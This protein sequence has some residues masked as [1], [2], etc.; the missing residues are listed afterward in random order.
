MADG[1]VTANA[2]NNLG[3]NF[4]ADLAGNVV[5]PYA[6]LAFG[7]SGTQTEASTSNP[8]PVVANANATV[9]IAAGTAV[10]G[11][12]LTDAGSLTLAT[13]NANANVAINSPVT[14]TGS[15]AVAGTV[16]VS[17]GNVNSNVNGNVVVSGAVT[18][19]APVTL[20]AN[21]NVALN[22]PVTLQTNAN[23]SINSPITLQAN[24]NVVVSALTG[25]NVN[26]NV[27]G[28]V[29]VSGSVV[30]SALTG[31]NVNA[32]CNGNIVVTGFGKAF[33]TTS[34]NT[35]AN[36]N[37]IA[38]VATKRLKV[39]ALTIVSTGANATRVII[40]SNGNA[41]T[42]MWRTLLQGNTNAPMGYAQSVTP[43]GY[44]FASVAGENV[45]LTTTQTDNLEYSAAYWDDDT[46]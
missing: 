14:V 40:K 20:Q 33:K 23:V 30:V 24:A 37:I 43:P 16:A 38:A 31:G 12:V 34:N 2:G 42:E 32:N 26:S 21:A 44:L 5:W 1:S 36:A 39:Y 19:S 4:A 11:H 28:N 22:A 9:N 6:K 46:V 3:A 29:V 7:A 45:Q 10:I 25:G 35:T 18:I 27:N 15:V 8:L 41:G 17:G 13:L